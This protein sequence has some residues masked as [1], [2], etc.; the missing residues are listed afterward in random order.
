MSVA[1]PSP[2]PGPETNDPLAH[3]PS[4]AGG[5][6]EARYR[7]LRC[8]R[9]SEAVWSYGPVTGLFEPGIKWWCAVT[10]QKPEESANEGWVSRLCTPDDRG[11][12]GGSAAWRRH[13]VATGAPVRRR[14]PGANR[15]LGTTVRWPFA[16]VGPPA[17]APIVAGSARSR[18]SPRAKRAEGRS[19]RYGR[20][21]CVR[22]S[23]RAAGGAGARAAF[24]RRRAAR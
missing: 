22:F 15:P 13:S 1:V 4:R 12:R 19:A 16:G 21:N 18:I 2:S 9:F 11:G 8:N 3:A 10:G 23:R 24:R 20:N 17:K 6:A 14:V 7:A 5:P